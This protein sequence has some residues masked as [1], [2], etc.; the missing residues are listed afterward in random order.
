MTQLEKLKA[1]ADAAAHAYTAASDAADGGE[2]DGWAA[3]DVAW[4]TYEAT[5]NAWLAE[6]KKHRE[7]KT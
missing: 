2:P 4:D 1:A 5:Y 3:A 7:N 6:T